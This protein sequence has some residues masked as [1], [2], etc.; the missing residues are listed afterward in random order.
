MRIMIK[1]LSLYLSLIAYCST[2]LFASNS[3]INTAKK[4]QLLDVSEQQ[5]QHLENKNKELATEK[6]YLKS[7]LDAANGLV[8]AYGMSNGHLSKHTKELE[9]ENKIL[10][11]QLHQNQ[12]ASSK[13][14]PTK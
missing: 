7:E 3:P 5:I 6:A 11:A 14:I 4:Q 2:N 9:Q 12:A 13:T 10:K 1:K 8:C